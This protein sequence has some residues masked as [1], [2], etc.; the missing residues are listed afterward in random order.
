MTD[1][2]EPEFVAALLAARQDAAT[3]E[4]DRVLASAQSAGLD[5]T[6]ARE[7]K[8]W[9]RRCLDSLTEH[10]AL[11]IPAALAAQHAS[12]VQARTAVAEARVSW[13]QARALHSESPN[14]T[15][16]DS[17]TGQSDAHDATSEQPGAPTRRVG[18]VGLTVVTDDD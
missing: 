17:E 1:D 18:G 14:D 11:V 7:L 12:D 4:F 8:Y 13:E 16:A 3:A 10:A 9:Q 15:P 6:T 2:L 5:P